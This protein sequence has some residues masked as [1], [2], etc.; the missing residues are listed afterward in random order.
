MRYSSLPPTVGA[1]GRV[2][3]TMV[4]TVYDDLLT[5]A[6]DL[7][8]GTPGKRVSVAQF[9]EAISQLPAVPLEELLQEYGLL[10]K[11]GADKLWT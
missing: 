5:L 6:S 10:P 11:K 2:S 1:N 4:D 7:D 9:L 3:F 8:Y